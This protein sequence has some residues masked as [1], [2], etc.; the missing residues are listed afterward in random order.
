MA[1]L[2]LVKKE[3]EWL[4]LTCWPL[5][6]HMPPQAINC[7]LPDGISIRELLFEPTWDRA[8]ASRVAGLSTVDLVVAH[9][10]VMGRMGMILPQAE[11]WGPGSYAHNELTL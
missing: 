5:G 8:W 1:G 4:T 6:G 2:D 11:I 7:R 9:K 10:G 3:E